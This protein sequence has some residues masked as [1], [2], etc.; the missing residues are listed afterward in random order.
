MLPLASLGA[1]E[2]VR[3][4]KVHSGDFLGASPIRNFFVRVIFIN[5][6][7]SFTPLPFPC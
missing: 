2:G 3:P 7:P 4:S 5:E 6:A 1:D